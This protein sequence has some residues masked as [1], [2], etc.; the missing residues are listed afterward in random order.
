MVF[1]RRIG[2]R[3]LRTGRYRAI[4]QATDAGQNRSAPRRAAFRI[5]R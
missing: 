3:V 2:S 1:R 4:A 5:V